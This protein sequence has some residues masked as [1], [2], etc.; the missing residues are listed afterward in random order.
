MNI[1]ELELL[2]GQAVRNVGNR[3]GIP[4][5]DFLAVDE[6]RDAIK[7]KAPKIS[8]LLEAFINTYWEWFDFHRRVE[9]QG[10]AGNLD[11]DDHSQLADLVGRRNGARE[12]IPVRVALSSVRGID[13]L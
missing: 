6:L 11:G 4:N 9:T 1:Y 7:E 5:A 2:V 8:T 12:T 10:K 13:G 3:L